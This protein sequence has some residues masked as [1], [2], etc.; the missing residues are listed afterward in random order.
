MNKYMDIANALDASEDDHLWEEETKIDKDC[1][2]V[3]YLPPLWD[4]DEDVF[5]EAGIN[6]LGK[7]LKMTLKD[8]NFCAW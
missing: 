6:C 7:A 3:E 1:E 5:E 4:A 8:F 2:E